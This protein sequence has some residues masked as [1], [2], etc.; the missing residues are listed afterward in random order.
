MTEGEKFEQLVV[1]GVLEIPEEFRAK[2]DNVA[3][4]ITDEPTP[5]QRRELQLEPGGTLFGLYEG[6]PQTEREN[7][8]FVPPDK[9]TIFRGPIEREAKD[10]DDLR[11]IVRLTVWHEIAHHFG[12]DEAD[13]ELAEERR[14]NH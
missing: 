11:E 10:E 7:Y 4:V 5:K 6:V 13:V 1:E 12:M 8:N 3:L 2:L 9:I 14:R